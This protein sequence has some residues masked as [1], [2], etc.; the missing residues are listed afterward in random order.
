MTTVLDVCTLEEQRSAVRLLWAK[1]LLAKNSQKKMLPVYNENYLSC[2]VVYNCVQKYFEG[3]SNVV[4]EERN[5]RLVQIAT[6]ETVLKVEEMITVDKSLK[7]DSMATAM[8]VR[9]A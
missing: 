6:E 5:D 3:C 7:V 9:M 8:G 1:G 4:D 2:Q